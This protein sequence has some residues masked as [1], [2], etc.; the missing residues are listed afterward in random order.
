M[1]VFSRFVE[2]GRVVMVNY[3]PDCGKYAVIVDIIDQSRALID[4]PTSGVNRQALSFR[5]MHL[6]DLKVAVPRAAKSKTLL[7]V[8]Q[9]EKLDDQWKA[10]SFA[11]KQALRAKRASL[12]DF[13]RFKVMLAKKQ[14]R[15]VVYKE[16]AALKKKQ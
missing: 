9:K 14:R 11:K 12:T 8:I 15:H 16:V 7:K 3:G 6:T 4:G 5:R 10:T 1:Q 13:D 2:V